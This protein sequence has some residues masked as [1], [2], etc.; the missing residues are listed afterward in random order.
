MTPHQVDI[1]CLS[2]AAIVPVV[3]IAWLR[4]IGVVLGVLVVWGTLV[5]AGFWLWVLDPQR[6]GALGDSFWLLFGWIGGLL[7]CLPVFA[8]RELAAASLRLRSVQAATSSHATKQSTAA[9]E[10]RS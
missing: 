7:Y 6:Q 4:W 9:N 2:I 1:L 5:V 10:P 3:L 8:V